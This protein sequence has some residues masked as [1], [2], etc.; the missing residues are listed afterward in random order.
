MHMLSIDMG[1]ERD[2]LMTS[3]FFSFSL[4]GNSIILAN[5]AWEEDQGSPICLLTPYDAEGCLPDERK[6]K[7][8]VDGNTEETTRC[9]HE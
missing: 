9:I 6:L 8:T 3:L 1:P 2:E 4:N 7:L 5:G